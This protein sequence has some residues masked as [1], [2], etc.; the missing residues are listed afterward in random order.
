MLSLTIA[1]YTFSAMVQVARMRTPNSIVGG[2]G[3]YFIA[4]ASANHLIGT[5][6]LSGCEL[7]LLFLTFLTGLF[8]NWLLNTR[9]LS[10]L[11]VGAVEMER[12]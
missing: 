9:N 2:A 11:V 10:A 7:K 6:M 3:R 12:L 4:V 8:V 5:L 1:N